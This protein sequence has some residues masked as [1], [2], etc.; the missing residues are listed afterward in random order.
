MTEPNP[1]SGAARPAAPRGTVDLMPDDVLRWR[2]LERVAHDL[3][4]RYGYQELRTP[5]IEHTRLFVRS[6]GEVTDIVEKE[7][8]TFGEGDDSVSLR[9]EGTASAVR[10][11]LEHGCHQQA[12]F[13]KWYYVGPMFRRERPQAGRQRQFHQIGVEVLGSTDP[14]LDVEVM[15]LTCRFFDAIGLAGYDLAVNTIGDPADRDRYREVLRTKLTP[16]RA[17]LCE[18]C[19][20]RFERNVFRILDCKEQQCRDLCADLPPIDDCLSDASRAHWQAV[21]AALDAS[22]LPHRVDPRL[23]RG[24]DY[25]T[26]TVF[27]VRHGALGARDAICGGGR[28]DNLIADLGGPAL[29]ALGF[30][31]GTE[32]TL[33]AAEKTGAALVAAQPP[34]RLDA[35]VVSITPDLRGRAY[36]LVDQLRQA[37]VAADMDH[38]ERSPR[39]QFRAAN[40]IGARVVVVLGPDEAADEA[41]TVKNMATGEEH[42]VAQSGLVAAVAD[43]LAADGAND[44]AGGMA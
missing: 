5:L 1:E 15:T 16:V 41:V 38:E 32:A 34:P 8:Y 22:G 11:Y 23:V 43:L 35:F 2:A 39:K 36:I 9:P 7:M 6:I 27:E 18:N 20:R 33:L 21:T 14:L 4:A 44:A 17:A 40:A 42:T 13:Q 19:R 10:A 37:G 24:F 25:Y 30:G 3:F 12:R 28:Y 26:Q 29:G 31:I